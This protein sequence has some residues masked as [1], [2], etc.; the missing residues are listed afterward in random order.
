M[1]DDIRGVEG[2][3]DIERSCDVFRVDEYCRRFDGNG[4]FTGI[5]FNIDE[6]NFDVAT[7]DDVEEAE[8]DEFGEI[9]LF[10]LSLDNERDVECKRLLIRFCRARRV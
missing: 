8:N 9:S 10:S 2:E 3:T 5:G 7:D 4:V 1:A 6:S